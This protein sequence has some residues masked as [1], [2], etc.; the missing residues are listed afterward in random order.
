MLLIE[1][2]EEAAAYLRERRQKLQKLDDQYRRT[3]DRDLKVEMGR[4][5][6]EAAKKSSEANYQLL[7]NLDEFRA[8]HKY[9][10][11]LLQAYMEDEYIGRVVSKKSWLLDYKPIPPQQAAAKLEQLREWR[12]ELKDA[13][14][15][16]RRWVGSI[17]TAP[18]I[19][20]YPILRGY[21]S[22][23]M[24]KS[25]A[26]LGIDKADKVLLKEGWLLLISDSL[27]QI[28]IAKFM[29][30]I[31][32]LRYEESQAK[33]QAVRSAGKG[34]VA[35]TNALRK[36]E[37]VMK[38]LHHYEHVLEQVL[39]ANPSYL[40]SLKK[41][42]SWTSKERSGNLDRIAQGITPR[43]IK[44]RVWLDDMKKKLEGR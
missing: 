31:N 16:L 19:E 42:R 10:P 13:K 20:R 6:S 5:R 4:L 8:L 23:K 34:T 22:G 27:I 12:V 7:L 28:P 1:Y 32:S 21:V 14:Q 43:S 30:R 44:E 18:I 15:Y 41:R 35:E 40:R 38:G 3:Y 39:L 26:L 29:S 37:E 2:L 25:D 9:F 33:A 24:D 17:D 11:E 36:L